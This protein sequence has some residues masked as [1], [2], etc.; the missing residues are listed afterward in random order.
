MRLLYFSKS[1][2]Y[3]K[4]FY[5]SVKISLFRI[6]LILLV[7]LI[8]YNFLLIIRLITNS[9]LYLTVTIEFSL[10]SLMFINKT[11]TDNKKINVQ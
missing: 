4:Y 10:L 8:M 5:V 7:F 11:L 6:Y 9:N 3:H 1:I 2:Q